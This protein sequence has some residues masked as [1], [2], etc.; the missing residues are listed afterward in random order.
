LICGK[1]VEVFDPV[2]FIPEIKQAAGT[3]GYPSPYE[4]AWHESH[5]GKSLSDAIQSV[6]NQL[7]VSYDLA[8]SLV[9]A[10]IAADAPRFPA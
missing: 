6:R 5:S 8:S 4:L 9:W 10:E 7:G 2:R 3:P 1:A